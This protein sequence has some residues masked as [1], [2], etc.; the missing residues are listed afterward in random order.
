MRFLVVAFVC[1]TCCF[2][3]GVQCVD[4]SFVFVCLNTAIVIF[5]AFFFFFCRKP[6]DL[7]DQSENIDTFPLN[8]CV[9]EKREENTHTKRS[10]SKQ[11]KAANSLRSDRKNVVQCRPFQTKTESCI[12][13][14]STL[15]IFRLSLLIVTAFPEQTGF[16]CA[17]SR[18]LNFFC[19]AKATIHGGV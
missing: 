3:F 18:N 19:C 1:P 16:G 10:K 2:L 12:R 6:P 5:C 8:L 14:K 15:T 13:S 17:M 9:C 7:M 4:Y 11:N